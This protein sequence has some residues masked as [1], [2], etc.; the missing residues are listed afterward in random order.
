MTFLMVF[1]IQNTQNRDTAALQLKIDEILRVTKG[2][3]LALIDTE[4]LT[5]EEQENIRKHFKKIAK[6]AH[7][8]QKKGKEDTNTPTIHIY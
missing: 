4:E 8:D 7:Q 3:H 2:A 6:K 1:L 5:E